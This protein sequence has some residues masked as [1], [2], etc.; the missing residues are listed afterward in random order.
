M[1][2]LTRIAVGLLTTALLVSCKGKTPKEDPDE[3]KPSL[4]TSTACELKIV[5]DYSNFEA[6]EAEF[7][8]FNE[9]YPNVELSYEKVDDYT[10]NIGTVLNKTEGA[11]NIFFTYAAW[12]S[13]DPKYDSV[14]PHMEDLSDPALKLNL[15]CIRP[16]LLTHDAN[17]KVMMVPVFSRT[18]GTLVN[19]DL[20]KKENISIPTTWTE[21]LAACQ[22]FKNKEYQSPMMGYS[23]KDS[24]CLMNTIAYPGFIVALANNPEALNKANNL[25]PSAGEYMRD[26]LTKVKGLVDAGSINITE[27][28]K[29]SDNYTKVILRFFEGDVPMMICAG[30]TVSGTKKRESQSEAFKQ[31]P[32][33]YSF[34]PIPLSDQGGY[35]IDS[36]SIQFSVNK[37]CENLDMTNEFMKFLIRKPELNAMASLKRLVTP[38]TELSFDPVYAAFGQI[39]AERTFSPEGLGVKDP[40]AKQIRI[41]SFK[42]GRGELTVDQAVEKYGTF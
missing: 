26:A 18:Y 1:K 37:D 16:G 22:S 21:L 2:K 29:I 25:D 23:V 28:D 14:L 36:P 33:E 39:P 19:N 12:M 35:F 15:N 17:N 6:L 40:L 7:D 42:V 38:T 11:P 13:G 24:S 3:F 27:C 31:H 5:G 8:K 10:N 20:F 34:V 30:D 4:D 9:I 41:A 32:F